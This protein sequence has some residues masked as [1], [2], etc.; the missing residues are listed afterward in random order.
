MPAD[1]GGEVRPAAAEE[2]V[3]R[4]RLKELHQRLH[5]ISMYGTDL[6]ATFDFPYLGH[7]FAANGEQDHNIRVRMAHAG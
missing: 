6:P 3:L 1:G 2:D 4:L 5:R 7:L